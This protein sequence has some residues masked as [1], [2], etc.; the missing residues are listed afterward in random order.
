MQ[1]ITMHAHTNTHATFLRR[2][3][4]LDAAS[5]LVMGVAMTGGA[6]LAADLLGLPALL[7]QAAGASLIP[8]AVAIAWLALRS[9]PPRAGVIAIIVC[10]A[11]WVADSL[12]MLE[13]F[14]PTTL[15]VAFILMQAAAVAVLAV[16]EWI[17]LRALERQR[18]SA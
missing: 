12:L 14:A 15:G 5:C 10:N 1:N 16:L 8:F 6:G 2:V 18:R 13:W 4:A 9:V 3:L 7:L 11:V 17:G